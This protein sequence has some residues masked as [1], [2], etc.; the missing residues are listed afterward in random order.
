M[1]ANDS[2]LQATTTEYF[3][4]LLKLILLGFLLTAVFMLLQ[5]SIR[6]IAVSFFVNY[7]HLACVVD[8]AKCI[9]VTRVRPSV[10][11]SVRGRTL[12]LLR[13]PG[14]NLGAW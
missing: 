10:R 2:A 13:V 4:R 9:V 12:T 6:N 11:P 3:D 8:D 1:I 14:C 5:W 7:L